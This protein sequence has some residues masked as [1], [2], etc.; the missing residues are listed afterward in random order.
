MMIPSLDVSNHQPF[1]GGTGTTRSASTPGAQEFLPK[2]LPGV[3]TAW[4]NL[5]GQVPQ[6][7]GF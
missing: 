1:T 3:G 2:E 7:K 4:I 5:C 6:E